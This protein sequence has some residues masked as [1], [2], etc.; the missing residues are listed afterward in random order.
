MNDAAVDSVLQSK[1]KHQQDLISELL[2]DEKYQREAFTAVFVKEDKRHKDICQ[3]VEQ[4]Q[5]E[6]ASLTVIEM[7]KKDLKVRFQTV[8]PTLKSSF[9]SSG[10]WLLYF[11]I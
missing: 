5:A 8:L 1:G 6:L 10:G 3:Q 4:I 9:A 2:A 11:F 7:T